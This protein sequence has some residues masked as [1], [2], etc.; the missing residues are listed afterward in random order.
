VIGTHVF[1]RI[2]HRIDGVVFRL[3]GGSKTA[4]SALAGLPVIMLTTTGSR[5]ALARTVPLLGFPIDG[6]IAVAAG[7]FGR[8]REPG[9]CLNLRH[10]PRARISIHGQLRNVVAQ[11]MAGSERERIWQQALAIY[12]GGAAYAERAKNRTIAVFLL[13]D[14]IFESDAVRPAAPPL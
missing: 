14:Q 13:R 10:D 3:S 4:T 1:A 11:E 6:Q 12:P 8:A 2:L 9:W 5:S 7:N